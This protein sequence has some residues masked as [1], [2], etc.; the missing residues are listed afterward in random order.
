MESI[1][2][3]DAARVRAVGSLLEI[4][5][6]IAQPANYYYVVLEANSVRDLA[7]NLWL[8]DANAAGPILFKTGGLADDHGGSRMAATAITTAAATRA[9]IEIGNAAH[10][11][12]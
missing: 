2:V 12:G 7:G 9:T 8:D 10:L 11:G 4:Q 6:S 5:P 3:T 1:P